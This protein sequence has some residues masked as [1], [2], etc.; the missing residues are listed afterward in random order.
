M[1]TPH[2]PE[3]E[4]G[5]TGSEAPLPPGSARR[6]QVGTEWATLHRPLENSILRGTGPPALKCQSLCVYIECS[7]YLDTVIQGRR[8]CILCEMPVLGIL[9]FTES[10][11]FF[12]D[13]TLHSDD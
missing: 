12:T 11:H 13:W 8:V 9:K 6:D 10:G 5:A 7:R 2:L 4:G 3:L 1:V